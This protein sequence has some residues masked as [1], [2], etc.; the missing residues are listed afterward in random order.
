MNPASFSAEHEDNTQSEEA[1]IDN[2][3]IRQFP[4]WHLTIGLTSICQIKYWLLRIILIPDLF[5]IL[6]QEKAMF[7]PSIHVPE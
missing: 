3:F 2:P 6:V 1:M 5:I 4:V 7:F